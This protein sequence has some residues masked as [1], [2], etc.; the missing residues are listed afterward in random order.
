MSQ[1]EYNVLCED[2]FNS[3]FAKP[4]KTDNMDIKQNGFHQI[5]R[6]TKI[7]CDTPNDK[8]HQPP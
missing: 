2:F 8:Y 6:V 3:V 5:L 4:F 7:L 1:K